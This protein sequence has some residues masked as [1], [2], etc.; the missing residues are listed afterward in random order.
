LG[1]QQS[2][3]GVA[4]GRLSLE[5]FHQGTA[6]VLCSSRIASG[7]EHGRQVEA[8][9]RIVGVQDEGLTEG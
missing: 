9:Q 7:V 6:K 3:N 8:S 1:I 2:K 4:L 5:F